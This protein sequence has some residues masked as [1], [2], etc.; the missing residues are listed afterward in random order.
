MR[1]AKEKHLQAPDVKTRLE[2]EGA[3]IIAST[4]EQGAAAVRADL[5]RWAE[6]IRKTG[7]RVE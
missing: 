4:P 5:D 1:R 2:Q 7:M 6:V 3:E